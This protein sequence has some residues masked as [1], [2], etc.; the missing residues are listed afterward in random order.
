M[1]KRESGYQ[2]AFLERSSIHPQSNETEITENVI[3]PINSQGENNE[4]SQTARLYSNMK[5]S[6]SSEEKKTLANMSVSSSEAFNHSIC[7]LLPLKKSKYVN[8]QSKTLSAALRE[9]P[10]SLQHGRLSLVGSYLTDIDILPEKLSDLVR[11]LY[12]SNN[13]LTTLRNVQQ[14]KHLTTLSLANNSI[15]YLHALYPLSN[16]PFLEKVSLEGNVVTHMPYYRQFLIGICSAG[17]DQFMLRSIDSILLTREEIEKSQINFRTCS[18]Q[19]EQMRC[20]CLRVAVLE[21]MHFLFACHAELVRIV[22]G[23]F[24]SHKR[25]LFFLFIAGI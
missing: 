9:V 22:M 11:T 24:R 1:Q 17:N 2:R 19:L 3:F 8:V 23:K 12:L 20:E 6:Q 4:N 7:N 14:F 10:L 13:S 16:L 21:H 18:L 5:R 15:R 25:K